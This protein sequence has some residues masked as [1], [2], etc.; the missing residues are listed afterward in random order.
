MLKK[1]WS[2][3]REAQLNP[4]EFRNKLLLAKDSF[5]YTVWHRE[6][7]R[8]GLQALEVLWI[9]AKRAGLNIVEMN[10]N[11]FLAQNKFGETA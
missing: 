1:L 2:W 7:N 3:A 11:L 10:N 5:G 9:W 6:A 8:G 4:N